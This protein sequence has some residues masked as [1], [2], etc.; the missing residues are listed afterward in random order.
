MVEKRLRWVILS[1]FIGAVVYWML[2]RSASDAD[3]SN[4][5]TEREAVPG[6][7]PEINQVMDSK[8]SNSDGR[9]KVLTNQEVIDKIN[10]EVAAEGG[11]LQVWKNRLKSVESEAA[12]IKLIKHT[13]E[14]RAF[15]DKAEQ[16]LLEWDYLVTT[17][18][19]Q[20]TSLAE[21]KAACVLYAK[22][23]SLAVPSRAA[24]HNG[25]VYFMPSMK[26]RQTYRRGDP[27][28][29]IPIPDDFSIGWAIKIAEKNQI[30]IYR[31]NF[32]EL[33]QADGVV[34]IRTEL[35]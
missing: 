22:R 3:H 31:W 12:Q 5:Q 20:M 10:R 27:N 28:N 11:P 17:E 9:E 35:E 32:N 34:G 19:A 13:P 25:I 7:C 15:F 2:L 6:A 4:T 26:P 30:E 1:A 16:S 8:F 23:Y 21:A 18:G 24:S 14:T 29:N 33:P